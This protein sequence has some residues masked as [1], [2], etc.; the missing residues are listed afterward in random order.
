MAEVER[1]YL[2]Q[3]NLWSFSHRTWGGR[4]GREGRG[5]DQNTPND[6][7]YDTVEIG[8]Q[9]TVEMELEGIKYFGN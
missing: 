9:V 2:S 4:G 6:W 7:R 3:K 5:K 8:Y 1:G